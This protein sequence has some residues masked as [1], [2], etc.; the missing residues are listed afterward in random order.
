MS[1]VQEVL[2]AVRIVKA[3][4]QEDREQQRFLHH[5]RESVWARIRI[6]IAEGGFGLLVG[7]IIATGTAAVLFIGTRHVQS[8]VLTLGGLL[9]VMTY[10]SQLYGPLETLSSMAAHMQGSLVSAQRA[11]LLLDETPDVVE[12]QHAIPLQRSVGAV[13]FDGVSFAYDKKRAVLNNVS[14][15]IVPKSRVGIT[16]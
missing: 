7:L 15:E 6:A 12:R 4:G 1:V 3:F 5:S 9:M 8:G 14:F 10:I 2:S 13:T 16:G 11:F